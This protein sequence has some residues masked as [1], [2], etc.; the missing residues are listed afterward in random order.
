MTSIGV[1]PGEILGYGT[2][3]QQK[4]DSIIDQLTGLCNDCVAVA[5]WGANSVQFKNGAGDLAETF[6][7]GVQADMGTIAGAIKT[8]TSNI[9]GSLGG[10]PI[11]IQVDGKPIVAPAAPA[12][13]G[14]SGTDTDALSDLITQ[15]GTR[16]TAVTGLFDSHLAS[17]SSL[18]E[19]KGWEGSAANNTV[20]QVAKFTASAK[21]KAASA[22]DGLVKYI[23]EQ[24]SAVVAAD[25]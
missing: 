10:Q 12:D 25:V 15:V 17:L 5:F 14:D 9:S 8:A 18:V 13:T 24:I 16:F 7:K 20:A 3:A 11:S 6:A 21:T 2:T 23:N 22:Q 4:F 19:N 1:K